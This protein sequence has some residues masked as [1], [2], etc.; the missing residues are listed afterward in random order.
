MRWK[1]SLCLCS[2]LPYISISSMEFALSNRLKSFSLGSSN[3][4]RAV[5]FGRKRRNH[6]TFVCKLHATRLLADLTCIVDDLG[7]QTP[8]FV[9]VCPNAKGKWR[10][11]PDGQK[12][13]YQE[14]N[15]L[16]YLSHVICWSLYG[17]SFWTKFW[18]TKKALTMRSSCGIHCGCIW[19]WFS[20][21]TI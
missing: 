7:T 16:D 2:C 13:S 8:P 6:S 18:W 15:H 12:Y 11:R 3:Y 14:V 4:Q 21:N 17:R 10:M 1:F 20:H 5:R 9:F 19:S